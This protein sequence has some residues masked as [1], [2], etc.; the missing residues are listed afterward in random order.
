MAKRELPK[1][2]ALWCPGPVNHIQGFGVK[3]TKYLLTGLLFVDISSPYAFTFLGKVYQEFGPL[4]L[5]KLYRKDLYGLFCRMEI[6]ERS[7]W[8]LRDFIIDSSRLVDLISKDPFPPQFPL[9]WEEGINEW[10][11]VIQLRGYLN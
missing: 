3:V 7:I 4:R 9:K 2:T 10:V 8:H 1:I 6:E 11:P 5:V